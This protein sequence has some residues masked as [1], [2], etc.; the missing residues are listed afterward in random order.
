MSLIS[1]LRNFSMH[2]DLTPFPQF[3][4]AALKIYNIIILATGGY[5]NTSLVNQ[6]VY[7]FHLEIIRNRKR[8]E[9]K[10][11]LESHQ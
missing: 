3:H 7:C 6:C 1:L 10:K 8:N 4:T 5:C 11:N 9:K 2:V